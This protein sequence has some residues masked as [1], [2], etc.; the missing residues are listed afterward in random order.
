MM[1]N[2]RKV[3]AWAII[4]LLFSVIQAPRVSGHCQVPCGIYDDTMRIRMIAEHIATIRKAMTQIGVLSRKS[5]V[6]YNQ[7]VRWVVN[8]E[9]HAEELSE[10][11]TYYFMAQRLKPV[12]PEQQDAYERYQRQLQLLHNILVSTMKAKQSVDLS[13]PD[14]LEKGLEEF[15][16][17]YFESK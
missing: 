16:Q 10:I 3:F 8:K 6:N 1:I 17:I 4:V 7:L 15:K 14:V 9:K 5:P 13:I 12:D 11:V 2:T